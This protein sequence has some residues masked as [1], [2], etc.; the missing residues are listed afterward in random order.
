MSSNVV[1]MFNS[2]H[3]IITKECGN[4]KIQ[5][6]FDSG[7]VLLA[8][9][10][11]SNRLYVSGWELNRIFHRIIKFSNVLGT[12]TCMVYKNNIPIAIT[13]ICKYTG[14]ISS[15]TRK[16][17]RNKGF[18]KL[19]IQSLLQAIEP[20]WLDMPVVGHNTGSLGCDMFF[21][22]C[23]LEVAYNPRAKHYA[24]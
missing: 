11:L 17:E 6:S 15:F 3:N 5:Y 24:K 21:K 7:Q 2:T 16:A 18:G 22:K 20:D 8:K 12:A 23:G 13:V 10:A 1:P 9:M 14:D 19:S 4:I